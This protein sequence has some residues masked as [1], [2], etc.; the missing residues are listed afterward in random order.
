MHR[1]CQNYSSTPTGNIF[2][3]GLIENMYNKT[4]FNGQRQIL[5][6][7]LKSQLILWYNSKFNK[8]KK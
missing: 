5:Q 2:W 7:L 1:K 4:G 3:I 8:N 6:Y